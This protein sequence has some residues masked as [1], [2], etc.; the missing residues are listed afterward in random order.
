MDS[1]SN[2]IFKTNE[3]TKD[4]TKF[5][6]IQEITNNPADPSK[7][8][9]SVIYEWLSINT[10]SK[11]LYDLV[12]RSFSLNGVDERNKID[13]QLVNMVDNKLIEKDEK[14]IRLING[15]HILEIK[16]VRK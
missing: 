2:F 10:P 4:N 7:P 5:V 12:D 8:K 1:F 13:Y 14:E 11:Y 6:I 16:I 9:I 15:V 3:M